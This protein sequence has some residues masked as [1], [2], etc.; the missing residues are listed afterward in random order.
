MKSKIRN[1]FSSIILFVCVGYFCFEAASIIWKGYHRF[2]RADREYSEYLANRR[3]IC[4]KVAFEGKNN[5]SK[6]LDVAEK[7]GCNKADFVNFL[8]IIIH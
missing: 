4:A 5:L 1:V 3:F 2:V 6:A 8:D 7:L